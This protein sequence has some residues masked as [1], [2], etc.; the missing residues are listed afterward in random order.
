M[1]NRILTALVMMTLMVPLSSI[2]AQEKQENKTQVE[3]KPEYKNAVGIRAGRTSG[4]TFK[5]F[6]NSGNAFEMIL[7]VWPNAVG[8]TALYEKHTATG[9]AGLKFYY[10]GGGHFTAETGRYYYRTYNNR[11]RSYEYRYGRDGIGIGIDGIVGLDYKIGMIPL[12]LSIDLKPFLEV[13]NYGDVY[14]AL[15]AGIGIKLAF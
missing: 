15:D 3:N 4:I 7:G 1:K 10:G 5:H 14:T 13:S 6:M 11:T 2:R 8:L 12:A 9:L